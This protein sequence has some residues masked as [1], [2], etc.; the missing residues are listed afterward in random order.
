METYPL[1]F[2]WTA[3]GNLSSLSLEKREA[4]ANVISWKEFQSYLAK[5]KLSVK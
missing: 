4:I 5:S 2:Y 3:K 1:N